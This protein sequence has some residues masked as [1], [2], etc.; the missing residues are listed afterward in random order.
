VA[1]TTEIEALVKV[2]ADAADVAEAL[3]T[4]AVYFEK[5]AAVTDLTVSPDAE[6]PRASAS[7]VTGQ[8]E[9]FVPL[10]GMID[11]E[12][13]R[14][15][16]QKEISQKEQFL[17]G[18]ERKLANQQF[19]T[20]APDEVVERERQKKRDATAELQRLRANLEELHVG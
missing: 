12:E 19:V 2:P 20:K 4:H 15:R 9:V 6:K 10:A 3:R 11:L 16:L 13:E 1:L 5:L 17:N 7:Y 8:Y 18:V 14:Q